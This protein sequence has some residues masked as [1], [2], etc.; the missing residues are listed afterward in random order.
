MKKKLLKF[1]IIIGALTVLLTL[2][3]T[4]GV[5]AVLQ[6]NPNTH[7]TKTDKPG[8]WME[9]FRNME[10]TGGALGLKET[11]DSKTMIATSESNNLDSHMMKSTEYGAIAILSV[12]GYGN[13]KKLQE[14]TIKTTTGNE[15]GLYYS[16]S[17]WEYVAGGYS[18]KIFSGVNGIYYDKYT[19]D[20]TLVKIGDAL[21]T[22]KATNSGCEGWHSASNS[23]W[24]QDH[25]PYFQ[26]GSKGLF[27]FS[28]SS[29]NISGGSVVLSKKY[30]RGVVVCGEG[31]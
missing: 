11:K 7:Y 3:T 16:G 15:T 5:Q 24:L 31:L 4:T 17:T 14:S 29:Y 27:S 26:R 6:S 20:K 21:G 10:T 28:Y 23:D 2:I 18:G 12:S 30:S 1:F 13:P 22:A 19:S 8:N 25:G 9:P